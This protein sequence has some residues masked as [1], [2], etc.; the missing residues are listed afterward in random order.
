MKSLKYYIIVLLLLSASYTADAQHRKSSRGNEFDFELRG[1]INLCQIDGDA[2]GSYNKIGYHGALNTSFPLSDDGSWRFVVE[3]GISQKG[4][5]I[6]SSS[7]D[8]HISL[9]YVEVPLMIAY[10]L[11]NN[12]QLRIGAGV[13]LAI[14]AKANVTTDGA[15]DALQSDNYKR[16][17]ALPICISIRYKFTEHIGADIRYYNSMLN[18]AKENGSGTYRIFRS[19]K[20]QFNRLL[21]AGITLNF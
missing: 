17:D 5:R 16:M 15:Y 3:L 21:Q 6:E 8:R 4:S 9:L 14:L 18:T 10:D 13:A 12:N 20:G 2:S 11:L 19:N 7:L 1:G